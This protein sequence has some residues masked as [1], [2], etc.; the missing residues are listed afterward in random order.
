L[1]GP[2]LRVVSHTRWEIHT[3]VER[4]QLRLERA[5][6][7]FRNRRARTVPNLTRKNTRRAYDRVYGDDRLLDEYLGPERV[8]FY[9]DVAEIG[10]ARQP[11]SVID[12]GCG[13]GHL[14]RELAERA[15]PERIVGIDHS[16][17]GIRRARELVPSAELHA[18]SL[19]ELDLGQTFDLVLCTEVL[20]HLHDPETAVERLV[21]LCAAG[22]A[23]VITVPDGASDEWGGHLNFWTESELADFLRPYGDVEL[24][25]IGDDLLAVLRP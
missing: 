6:T 16:T 4:Q 3:R 2:V 19:Y 18:L 9:R 13:A 24:R 12:V 7:D 8:V 15:A 10:A 22:G 14:L 1:L 17:A 25:R 5:Y 20:E 11:R 21:V 23:V